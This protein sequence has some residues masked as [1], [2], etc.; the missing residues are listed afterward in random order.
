[1]INNNPYN[2]PEK[3]PLSQSKIISDTNS[4]RHSSTYVLNRNGNEVMYSSSIFL[5]NPSV[6]GG[7][8]Q[9]FFEPL[10]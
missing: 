6:N 10:K 4:S 9:S 3:K 1:M 8:D 7:C 2:I 5:K